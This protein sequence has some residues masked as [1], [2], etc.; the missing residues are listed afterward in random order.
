MAF[1]QKLFHVHLI[2]GAAANGNVAITTNLRLVVLN[3]SASQQVAPDV[4]TA[5]VRGG[6]P[7]ATSRWWLTAITTAGFTFNWAGFNAGLDIRITAGKRHSICYD[8][9]MTQAQY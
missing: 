2:T 7:G 1:Q 4:I 9:S 5:E 8:L 6:D 3:N